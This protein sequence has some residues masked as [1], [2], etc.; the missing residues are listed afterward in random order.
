MTANSY[1]ALTLQVS[2]LQTLNVLFL[3]E[4]S[5]NIFKYEYE[6]IIKF[7]NLIFQLN[8]EI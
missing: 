6:T 8:N 1:G 7:I 3:D 4:F 2:L 5:K